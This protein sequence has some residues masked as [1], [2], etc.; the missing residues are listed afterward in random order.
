MNN[1]NNN[2]EL[3]HCEYCNQY[4]MCDDGED[5]VDVCMCSG[6]VQERLRRKNVTLLAESISKCC[7]EHCSD[8]FPSFEPVSTGVLAMMVNIVEL[9][10]KNDVEKAVISLGD[11][12]KVSITGS[13]VTRKKV[14]TAEASPMK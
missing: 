14:N 10:S 1:N 6:A 13:K 2:T 9:M 3:K 5:A 12:T 8:D 7:G 11:D 4:L